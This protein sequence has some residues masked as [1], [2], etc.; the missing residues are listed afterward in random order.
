MKIFRFDAE[1]GIP[2]TSFGS[3]FRLVPL[4]GISEWVKVD[5][6]H[7][8]PAGVI[9]RHPAVSRQLFAVVAGSGWASG[10]DGVRRDLSAGRAVLW[11][12]DEDHDAGTPYGMTAVVVQGSFDVEAF[13]VSKPIEV[14][15]YNPEWP[16]WFERIHNF[17]WPAVSDTAVRIEHVGSTSVP[18]LVAKPV[19][20]VDVVVADAE[21]VP[22]VIERI[23][24]LG[25]R[26]RGELGVVGRESLSAVDLERLPTHNLYVVVQNNKAHQDHWLFRDLLRA[27]PDARVRYAELK[28]A[29]A[30]TADD[31]IDVYVAGKASFVAEMLTRAREERGLPAAAYWV[32]DA[33]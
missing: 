22:V 16:L 18:G 13:L 6:I 15:D 10:A 31:D 2:V 14:V 12:P 33:P 9:G 19:I 26:W 21:A 5:V 29:N 27:D 23:A 20:D 28:L 4:T 8:E 1:V 11:E 3:A 25:Y 17:L 24:A 7:L 30:A 32:P